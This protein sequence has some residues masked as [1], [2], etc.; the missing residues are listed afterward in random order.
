MSWRGVQVG[1]WLVGGWGVRLVVGGS[2]GPCCRGPGVPLGLAGWVGVCGVALPWGLCLGPVSSEGPGPQPWVLW[3]CR[4]PLPVPVWWPLWRPGS[5]SGGGGVVVRRA[6]VFHAAPSVGVAR[7]PRVGVRSIPRVVSAGRWVCAGVIGTASDSCFG[8]ACCGCASPGAVGRS[9]GVGRHW[10]LHCGMPFLGVGR[11]ACRGLLFLCAS[12]PAAAPSWSLGGFLPPHCVAFGALSLWAPAP[13]LG[14]LRALLPERPL[15][16]R[17]L[18]LP[19][20]FPFPVWWWWG[21]GGA[22]MALAS[23]WVAW[24]HWRRAWGV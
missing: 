3:P 14:P 20:P 15:P 7:S 21:G 8:G 24:S 22:P 12:V 10:S 18:P 23:G 13:H 6:A 4:R 19:V 1:A 16:F 2:L 9:L 11:G 5:L 17:A